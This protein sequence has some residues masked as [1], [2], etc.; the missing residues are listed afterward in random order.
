MRLTLL[1]DAVVRVDAIWKMKTASGLPCASS[2]TV[3]VIPNV[4]AA[5]AYTPG[6]TVVEPSSVGTIT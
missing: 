3:P 1:A 4:P 5:E 2:V 6:S